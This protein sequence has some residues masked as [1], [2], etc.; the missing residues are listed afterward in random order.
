MRQVFQV[1]GGEIPANF[2]Y[3]SLVCGEGTA[4]CWNGV[5]GCLAA[6]EGFLSPRPELVRPR[7]LA[8]AQAR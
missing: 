3:E 1:L 7:P 5:E 8:A 4:T 2:C 6:K